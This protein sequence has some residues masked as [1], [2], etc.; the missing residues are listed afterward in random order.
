MHNS[1]KERNSTLVSCFINR[2]RE[3]EKKEE[4]VNRQKHILEK[5]IK[6]TFVELYQEEVMYLKENKEIIHD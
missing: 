3:R 2:E 1:K 4:F 6:L 5:E